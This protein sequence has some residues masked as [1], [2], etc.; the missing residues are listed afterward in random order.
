MASVSVWSKLES[1][2]D[3]GAITI[4]GSATKQLVNPGVA[5]L[6]VLIESEVGSGRVTTED[7]QNFYAENGWEQNRSVSW[8]DYSVLVL[9]L[10]LP[11]LQSQ[12]RNEDKDKKDDG[13]KKEDGDTEEDE[14]DDMRI[15]LADLEVILAERK[16]AQTFPLILPSELKSNSDVEAAHLTLGLVEKELH[17]MIESKV[18]EEKGSI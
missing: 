4:D 17:V 16:K 11:E 6:Q 8:E 12:V 2:F 13:D 7:I 18:A 10:N 1:S 9:S 14:E 3:Q 5:G 15:Q